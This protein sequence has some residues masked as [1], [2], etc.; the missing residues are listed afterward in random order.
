MSNLVQSQSQIQNV[1]AANTTTTTNANIKTQSKEILL[2]TVAE[3]R[4]G[5][6]TVH[7]RETEPT[8]KSKE[9]AYVKGFWTMVDKFLGGCTKL[10]SKISSKAEETVN[11]KKDKINEFR[12]KN[13]TAAAAIAVG[14]GALAVAGFA[15]LCIS[16]PIGGA[17]ATAAA[18]V[19]CALIAKVITA[20]AN[21]I[22]NGVQEA[23]ADNGSGSEIGNVIAEAVVSGIDQAS[24]AV[25]NE[26]TNAVNNMAS[27][28]SGNQT[29]ASAPVPTNT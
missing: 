6:G 7:T 1:G 2:N 8:G 25:T 24:G 16:T 26:V 20:A 29:P 10:A 18:G 9:G 27:H 28:I 17:V 19:A 14:V 11:T 15:A 21:E 22:K 3:Q 12:E 5:D 13:P 23:L 4:T